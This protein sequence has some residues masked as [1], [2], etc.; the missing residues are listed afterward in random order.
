MNKVSTFVAALGENPNFVA[1]M[2]HGFAAAYI[3]SRFPHGLPRLIAS[4]AAVVVAAV[5]EFWFDLRY[6]KTPPQ[7]F[8][9]SLLDFIGY[10]TGLVVGNLVP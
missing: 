9:D 2:A 5:K 8:H 6:E 4:G 3:S 1:F 7:T 10:M